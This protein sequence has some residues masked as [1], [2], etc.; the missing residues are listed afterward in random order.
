M[1]SND[2]IQGNS[3]QI[4]RSCFAP[5]HLALHPCVENITLVIKNDEISVGSSPQC[6]FFIFKAE[7]SRYGNRKGPIQL[8]RSLENLLG[9]IVSCTFNSFAKGASR[10]TREIADAFI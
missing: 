7:A 10:E 6:A 5:N 2:T 4:S 9:W 3:E 8:L 1:R